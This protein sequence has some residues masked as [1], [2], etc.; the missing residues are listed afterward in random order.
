MHS[1]EIALQGQRTGPRMNKH[2]PC[3]KLQVLGI[4]SLLES[5]SKLFTCQVSLV[6]QNNLDK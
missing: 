4:A 2:V 6:A 3:D 1:A 5:L